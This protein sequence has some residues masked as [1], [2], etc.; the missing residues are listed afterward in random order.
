MHPGAPMQP[1]EPSLREKMARYR[2]LARR[3]LGY[4]KLALLLF[5]VGCG[6][7]LGVAMNVKRTY[8][9]E[10]VILVKPGI[11]LNTSNEDSP[12]V[13]S[14]KLAAR[15]KDA[16][17]LRSKLESA[18]KKFKLYARTVDG[19]GMLDAVD[20]MR[21]HV[22]F[23][24]RDSGTFVVSF[25]A[26]EEDGRSTQDL[27]RD[28][29]QFLAEELIEEYA[30][31]NLGDL[32]MRADFLA[33]EQS[34]AEADLEKATRALTMFLSVH[35][36]FAMEAKQQAA[37]S[38]FGLAP[39]PAV[40]IPLLPSQKDGGRA[41]PKQPPIDPALAALYA[42][43]AQL[44]ALY[45]QRARLEAE[46]KSAAP[47]SSAPTPAPAQT[48]SIQALQEQITAA[49]AEVEAAAKRAAEAQADVMSKQAT[50][51]PEHPDMK[52]AVV[53]ADAAARQLALAKGKLA[54]LQAQLRAAQQ[55]AQPKDAP[56]DTVSA[57]LAQ[58]IKEVNGQ[59][60]A[61]E[62]ELKRGAPVSTAPAASASGAPGSTAAPPEP[63]V[64]PLVALES[65]WQR[66]LRTLSDAR[67]TNEALKK[68]YTDAQM[69]VKAAEAAANDL[70]SVIEQAYRPSHPSKGGRTP[71]AIA[72]F[73]AAL[74]V[75]LL[76]MAARVAFDDTIVD[77]T[78]VESLQL[79][80]V[81]GVVP[82]LRLKPGG[83][84]GATAKPPPRNAQGGAP[85]AV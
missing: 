64:S 85:R 73:A 78:D 10:C 31:G 63:A 72:G 27:V 47:A 19:K 35:P 76:Y 49:Q 11:V 40:G 69:Q 45:R 59:I 4:W 34:K 13:R 66:L 26:T 33:K 67:T 54:S 28:V 20:E 75:A 39:N 1:A 24:A 79:I 6:I 74:F 17:T 44:G 41:A 29:T 22:G 61:R 25:D 37:A 82:K 81:L 43:D 23:R 21:P 56:V 8:R 36:E 52:A 16:L 77:A 50:L 2:S 42:S 38:P 83:D 7:A 60:A 30:S 58:K 51:A 48:A 70:M 80:P 84:G 18:I 5:V 12:E 14:Q 57:E 32:K 46:I 71:A 55:P 3:G 68:Q 15:L 53:A 9:S 62:A 65:D